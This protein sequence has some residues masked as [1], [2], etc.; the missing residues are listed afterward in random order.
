MHREME[1]KGLD[2]ASF[3]VNGCFVMHYS[4]IRI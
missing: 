2:S 4:V 3:H 1:V